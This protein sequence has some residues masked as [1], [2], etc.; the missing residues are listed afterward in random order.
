MRCTTAEI[1]SI[2]AHGGVSKSLAEG[3]H[4]QTPTTLAIVTTA[5]RSGF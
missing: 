4:V 2:L 1:G 5:V 3:S